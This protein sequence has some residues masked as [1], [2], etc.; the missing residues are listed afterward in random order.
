MA[1]VMDGGV[2]TL[3]RGSGHSEGGGVATYEGF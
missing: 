3:G 1:T 2:A